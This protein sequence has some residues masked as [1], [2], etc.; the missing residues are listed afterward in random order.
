[1]F[2]FWPMW[3]PLSIVMSSTVIQ[4]NPVK[5]ALI[6]LF[7]MKNYKIVQSNLRSRNYALV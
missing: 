4:D 7:L 2:E 6:T 3:P 1:M 5:A